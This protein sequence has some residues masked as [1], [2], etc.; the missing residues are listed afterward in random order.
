[1]NA[2]FVEL[3]LAMKKIGS[4]LDVIGAFAGGT[5]VVSTSQK[6]LWTSTALTQ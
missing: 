6:Y 1:M 2:Q 3:T 5:L 4:G